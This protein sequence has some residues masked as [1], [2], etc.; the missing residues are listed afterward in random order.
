[1]INHNIKNNFKS[2][3]IIVGIQEEFLELLVFRIDVYN[4]H[5]MS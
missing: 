2:H 3:I 4:S 5:R 1:M